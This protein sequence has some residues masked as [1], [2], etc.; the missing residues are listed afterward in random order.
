L[1]GFENNND[2]ALKNGPDP[3]LTSAITLVDLAKN[4]LQN[5][6]GDLGDWRSIVIQTA[7]G[8]VITYH[9]FSNIKYTHTFPY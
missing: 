6:L 1:K 9:P 8:I 3:G 5:S 4:G 2:R 7:I